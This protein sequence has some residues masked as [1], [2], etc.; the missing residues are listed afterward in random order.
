MILAA[1]RSAGV[2]EDFSV[3][4]KDK[5]YYL[6]Y[7]PG[8]KFKRRRG[9][10]VV[11]NDVRHTVNM[12]IGMNGFRAWQQRP[13]ANRVVC[14]CGWAGIEHYRVRG[15]GVSARKCVPTAVC[16]PQFADVIAAAERLNQS[17]V[18]A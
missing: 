4:P 12:G 16:W 1:G 7:Y 5:T 15:T 17:R 14:R 6:R 3:N 8:P 11:H 18:S 10:I 2:N 13:A 9:M